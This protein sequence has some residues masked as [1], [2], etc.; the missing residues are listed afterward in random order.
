M[1]YI[2]LL[3]LILLTCAL[4]LRFRINTLLFRH[5]RRPFPAGFVLFILALSLCFTAREKCHILGNNQYVLFISTLTLW[6]MSFTLSSA[7][8]KCGIKYMRMTPF[9]S[10]IRID[11]DYAYINSAHSKENLKYKSM[12]L[13]EDIQYLM[14]SHPCKTISFSSHLLRSGIRGYISKSLAEKGITFT[15]KDRKTL[16]PEKM[17]LNLRYGG[18]T[19]YRLFTNLKHANGFKVHSN[20]AKFEIFNHEAR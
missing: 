17:V 9:G 5:L 11:I 20:G 4:R 12:E 6:F 2:L 3:I 7:T 15:V 18:R 13:V 8:L 16:L 19:R 14:D 1:V 10:D